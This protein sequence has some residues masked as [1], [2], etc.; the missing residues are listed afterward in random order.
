MKM[1]LI[2]TGFLLF[3]AFAKLPIGYYTF[4]RIVVTL[5]SIIIIVA[6]L[7]GGLNFWVILFS[8][9]AIVFNPI[10]PIYL[11]HKSIWEVIDIIC[12]IIFFTK[13]INLPAGVK[14]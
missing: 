13:S 5:V 12:G 3:L 9:I 14:L 4:L 10:F 2:I 1:V 11:G 8:F 6:E 7:N